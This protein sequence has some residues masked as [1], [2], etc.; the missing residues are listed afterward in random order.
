MP[1]LL[2]RTQAVLVYTFFFSSLCLSNF[3]AIAPSAI[4]MERRR[5]LTALTRVGWERELHLIWG[6]Q[7]SSVITEETKKKKP[8]QR[9]NRRFTKTIFRYVLSHIIP[10]LLWQKVYTR[11]DLVNP[12]RFFLFLFFQS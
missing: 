12:F 7:V 10:F 9:R 11:L 6:G 8:R 1:S 3:L 4:D 2:V 5:R